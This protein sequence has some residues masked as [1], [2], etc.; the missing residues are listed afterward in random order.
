[1]TGNLLLNTDSYK[2]SHWLQYPPSTEYVSSYIESRGGAHDQMVFFGLQAFIEKQLLQPITHADIDEAEALLHAHGLPFHRQGW[3]H[4]VDTH[5]GRLPIQ[6]EAVPEGT[7]L[8]TQ[9]VVC[10]VVNT[11]P[12]CYWLT[13]YLETALLRAI[14]YPSTVATRALHIRQTLQHFM[15]ETAG[16]RDGVPFQLHD[17]GARGVSSEETASL[18]GMAHLLVFQG[19]D[20]LSGLMAA[21]RFYRAEMPG[22]SIPAAEHATIT[23]WGKDR[24]VDAYRN[25]LQQFSGP[26]KMVAVVSDSYDLWHA[27]DQ[28]WGQDLHQAVVSQ[29]GTVVIR[30]DSGQPIEVVPRV[31]ESLMA[32]FGATTNRKGYRV[33][34]SCLRVIQGDG[35]S[36]E[37]IGQVLQ[38]MKDQGLSAE[39]IAFGMGAELLQKVNRDTLKFAMKASAVCIDGQWQGIFKA[40]Q[41]DLAKQSKPGRLALVFDQ[42]QYQTI[43]KNALGSRANQLRVVFS[44]GVQTIQEDFATIQG[45]LDGHEKPSH[46]FAE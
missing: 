8:P 43:A 46:Q 1:M 22:F 3:Q 45:R 44:E 27:L 10:Q 5:Q 23:S 33:L 14:W 28:I 39:N 42:G 15:D 18:G 35:V 7:C 12:A 32:K 20:N 30:P 2:A 36:P 31:I 37:V 11:D 24:E 38:A 6:I 29:G 25:M 9:H 41:T 17:F 16:H 40:P 26:N 34:P 4:I 13:S 19:T 21:R